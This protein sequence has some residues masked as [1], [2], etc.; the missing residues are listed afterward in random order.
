MAGHRM[1]GAPHR[2]NRLEG[3]GAA[4]PRRPRAGH[5]AER[6]RSAHIEVA[7]QAGQCRGDPQPSRPR[8]SIGRSEEHVSS[9]IS[10]Q[11]VLWLA[12]PLMLL[13]LCGALVHYFSSVAPGVISS[14]RR[15]KEAANALMARLQVESDHLSLD[16]NS[17][18]K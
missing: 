15:L 10:R 13:S 17:R 16:T 2:S 4:S 18:A 14:D 11:L 5:H 8:I 1:P 12:V 6:R 7:G 3:K 9:S